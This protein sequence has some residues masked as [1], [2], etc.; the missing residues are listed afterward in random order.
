MAVVTI[1]RQLGSGG[2]WLARKLSEETGYLLIDKPKILFLLG[3]KLRHPGRVRLLEERPPSFLEHLV[4][5]RD[6]VDE[7][8]ELALRELAARHDLV[9]VGRGGQ[10]LY[11][12][13]Q[14][15]LHVRV[16][17]PLAARVSRLARELEISQEEA[18]ERINKIDRERAD[19]LRY[20]YGIEVDDPTLYHVII[21]TGRVPLEEALQL[22]LTLTRSLKACAAMGDQ[23]TAEMVV[24]TTVPSSGDGPPAP[25]PAPAPASAP[26]PV[27][28]EAGGTAGVV[29]TAPATPSGSAS[30]SEGAGNRAP[31]DGRLRALQAATAAVTAR[32][33]AGL[34]AP[35]VFP[36]PHKPTYDNQGKIIF[37]H[38]SEAQFARVLDF[39]R[40]R[41]E[42]EPVTFPLEWSEDG[43]VLEAF[44][45]DFYLPD[46]NMFVELTTMRQSLVT[47]KNRKIR[48]LRELYPQINIKVFYSRDYRMLLRKL[49]AQPQE[50]R[51]KAEAE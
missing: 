6:D 51:P 9:V 30:G 3:E 2:D 40:V 26:T 48:Q 37:A 11:A 49:G 47:R 43:R 16:V 41:W 24:G 20:R 21:N 14:E 1:S 28:A 4:H 32:V 42:Y 35:P 15:A 34:P 39:Y 13:M 5:A 50:D 36:W 7:L 25:A 19:F 12:E 8:V 23:A 29:A 18:R 38:P 44:T 31:G 10:K 27:A 45:P 22:L 46:L 17:A 33:A